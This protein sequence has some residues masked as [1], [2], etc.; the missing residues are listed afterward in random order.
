LIVCKALYH[1]FRNW[2]WIPDVDGWGTL[3]ILSMLFWAGISLLIDLLMRLIIKDRGLL[4][5]VQALVVLAMYL[6]LDW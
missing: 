2:E 6:F 3:A 5:V 4:N 1:L